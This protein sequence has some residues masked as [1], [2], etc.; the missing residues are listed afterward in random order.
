MSQTKAQLIE[1]LNIN[2]S[3]PA[4]ALVIDSSGN[5]GVGTTSPSRTLHVNSGSTNEVARFESTDTEVTLE[6]KDST[7]TAFLKCRDDY[8]FNN[9]SGELVRIDS[10]GNVGIGSAAPGEKLDVNG[11][12][13]SNHA[14]DSRFLLRVNDVNK[15]G[16]Q[17]STDAGVVIYGASS[18]NPIKF[19][20]S[21]SEKA[22]IDTSGRLLLGTTTEGHPNLDDL[23]I[24]TTGHTGITIRS[25]TSHDGQIGFSDGTSGDDEYRGQ[26]LYNHGSN[27]MR[28]ITDASERM[29][30]DSS[31][32]LLVGGTNTYHA[33]ADDLVVQGTGKVGVTIASTN[34]DTSNIY[35]ADSTS[36]PGTYACYFEYDHVN[37]ALKIGQ[38]NNERLRLD[39]AGRVM[40]G[41][42][43]PGVAD[44]DQLTIASGS[45]T[46]I[47]I[48]GSTSGNGNVFF[49]DTTSGTGQYDGFIQ[50]QHS[51]RA[52]KFGTAAAEKMR[53]SSSGQVMIGTTTA[54][55]G[56]AD[57]LTI[58]SSGNTGI[59]IR[60]SSSTAAAIYFADGTSGAEN[61][62][63]IVQYYHG[64]D[65][66]QFYTNYGANSNPRM[67]IDSSGRLMLGTSTTRAGGF[68]IAK[69]FSSSGVPAAGTSTSSLLVGNDDG[70]SYGLAM[71]ANGSGNGYIQA[72]RSDGSSTIY[73]LYLQP[74]GGKV[75]IGTTAATAVLNVYGGASATLY[76]NSNTGTGSGDGFFVGNWGGLS[77]SVW[78]Y[79]NDIINF[80]TNNTE[81]MRIQNDGVVRI[82]QSGVN[83]FRV[84]NSTSSGANMLIQNSTTGL[85]AGNGLFFGLGDNEFSYMWNY[86]NEPII[87]GTNNQERVRL[88]R[89]GTL[90]VNVTTPS[91]NISN[92]Y[93]R[94][95]GQTVLGSIFS[96][97]RS[98][99]DYDGAGYNVGWQSS[100]GSYKY[101]ASD[102]AAFIKYGGGNGRIE[103][104]TAGAGTAGN[105]IS[106]TSGPYVTSGGTSWSTGSDERLKTNLS[107]IE[108]GLAKVGTLRAVTG[109]YLTDEESTSRA[110]L[111]AQDVQTV[112]PEAVDDYDPESLGL[113]YPAMIPLLVAALKEAKDK[114]ETLETS[115]ADLLARVTALEAG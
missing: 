38:G 64:S 100:N 30:I 42:A 114:I 47:T 92:H 4:D 3:A 78:N 110:F 8:R 97:G 11:K 57:D 59:T 50:Y 14:S 1:G 94:V 41:T 49:S 95:Y 113:D 89:A 86:H 58:A 105:S 27:S 22:R 106:F 96:V 70:G 67:L 90:L 5:V 45:S 32:R 66:L 111:I 71:G 54:G 6:L 88:D 31:G 73:D 52:L 39:S 75:S 85:G 37:D 55:N 74:N 56:A 68:A 77:G 65:A 25:G 17:A 18:T 10:S 112:L 48:R 83:T 20:T 7:G 76:Q 26:V 33:N 24:A 46:G 2:T 21:G 23:T 62:Q 63:G 87:L 102:S 69:G 82:Q 13:R 15:G 79:E 29:R 80:G 44:A 34:S 35:F 91:P 60:S 101:V 98:G 72:Q 108:N 51:S 36:N 99:G 84:Q 40:L 103:T 109:R 12:I 19:Q 61:Y 107:P 81:R 115:N 28:F 93:F 43:T 9:N 53:V 104:F 16:F